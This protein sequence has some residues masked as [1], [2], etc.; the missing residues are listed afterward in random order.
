M[1]PD[2]GVLEHPPALFAV[3]PGVG[4]VVGYAPGYP[5]R[6]GRIGE[7]V[8]GRAG[9]GRTHPP[10]V[11]P[12]GIAI[13]GAHVQRHGRQRLDL[14][15]YRLTGWIGEVESDGFGVPRT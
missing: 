4:E 3:H 1:A 5:P 8:D 13:S 11:R 10:A 12:V 9:P 15:R 14:N 7:V 6:H 2:G